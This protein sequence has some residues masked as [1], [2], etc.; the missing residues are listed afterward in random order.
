MKLI[1]AHI[2][3]F[4]NIQDSNEFEIDDLTCLVGK[5]ESG[6]TALLKALYQLNPIV[7]TDYA[8]DFMKDYP[9]RNLAD[10][11]KK[12]DSGNQEAARVVQATYMLESEDIKAVEESFGPECFEDKEPTLTVEKGYNSNQLTLIN[13]NVDT[14]STAR[15]LV[16]TAGLR[17]SRLNKL[18]KMKTLEEMLTYLTNSDET[19]VSQRLIPILQGISQND[20]SYTI[21]NQ[22]LHHRIPKFLYFDE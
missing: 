6:K 13:L 5:N 21:F 19:K 3:N 14:H 8:F 17:V 9:R 18:L 22:I 11:K 10:G 20:V 7:E 12:I 15:Y 16:K 1:K 2:T 4:Q